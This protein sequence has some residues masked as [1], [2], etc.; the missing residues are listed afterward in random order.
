MG[1][2]ILVDAGRYSVQ[3]GPGNHDYRPDQLQR[4]FW[5]VALQAARAGT[6]ATTGTG[7]E[8]NYSFFSA[9]GND[10]ILINLGYNPLTAPTWT[11]RMPC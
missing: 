4:L 10:F 8:N 5:H 1:R 11:G 6:R 9:S 7:N 2:L 3:R